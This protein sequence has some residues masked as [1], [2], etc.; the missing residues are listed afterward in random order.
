VTISGFAEIAASV[1]R[2]RRFAT[3]G[4]KCHDRHGRLDAHMIHQGTARQHSVIQ[5]GRQ[6]NKA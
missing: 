4:K 5:M 1:T 3:F 6:D 2:I